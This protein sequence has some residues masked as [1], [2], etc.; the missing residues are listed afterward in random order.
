M[1]E[2]GREMKL[3]PYIALVVFFTFIASRNVLADEAAHM[4]KQDSRFN[5]AG[6]LVPLGVATLFCIVVTL[7]LGLFI[8]KNRNILLPWHKR[9]AFL[10]LLLAILHGALALILF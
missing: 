10:T 2:K 9:M 5:F 8:R 1:A 4:Y 3:K 7:V 6:L